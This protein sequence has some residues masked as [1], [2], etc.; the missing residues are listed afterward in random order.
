MNKSNTAIILIGYQNDY[1]SEDGI[2]TGVVQ[3]TLTELNILENTLN[4]ISELPQDVTIISTPILFSD[5]YSELIEPIG[6]LEIIK[7]VQAF[8]VGT[9]GSEV[10]PELK[11]LS[12]RITEVTGKHGLNAFTG[13]IL[14]D[15]LQEKNISNIVLAGC[16]CSICI[17][18]TG[19]SAFDKGMNVTMLSD[20]ITGRTVFEQKF[21]CEEIF[22]LYAKVMSSSDLIS[23]IDGV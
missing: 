23:S 6:I 15:F 3:E 16:V 1:F 22:P 12:E 5:D 10:I 18:S 20:C 14:Y 11:D 2:L 4:L 17:D 21:Y 9:K 19:R 13:T 8:K 7:N